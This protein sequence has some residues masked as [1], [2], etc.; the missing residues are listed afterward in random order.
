M[1]SPY[2]PPIGDPLDSSNFDE[3][4]EEDFAGNYIGSQ[5]HFTHF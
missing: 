1:K 5:D 2:A 4:D 3:Y